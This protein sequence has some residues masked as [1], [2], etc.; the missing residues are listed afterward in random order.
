[1]L[2]VSRM[3]GISHFVDGY[4]VKIGNSITGWD[5]FTFKCS[6]GRQI[7]TVVKPLDH[8]IFASRW[9]RVRARSV[10]LGYA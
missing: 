5:H 4:L 6:M 1:M 7:F 9:K 3:G 8:A 10:T 2:R